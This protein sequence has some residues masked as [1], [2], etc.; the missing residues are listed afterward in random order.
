MKRVD[1][2]D[3]REDLTALQG[4]DIVLKYNK[5]AEHFNSHSD[6]VIYFFLNQVVHN[7]VK[8]CLG[9][10]ITTCGST[11]DKTLTAIY[12]VFRAL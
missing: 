8:W 5:T 3:E 1:P 4:L 10:T 2:V 9:V 12:D 7:S 6:F 11:V